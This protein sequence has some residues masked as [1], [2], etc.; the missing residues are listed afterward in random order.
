[1]RIISTMVAPVH[2][3]ARCDADAMAERY[4][5]EEVGA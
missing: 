3:L 1:M 2:E 5:H 4:T